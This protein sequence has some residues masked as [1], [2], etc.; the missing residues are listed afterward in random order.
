VTADAARRER[1]ERALWPAE[2]ASGSVWAVL[3]GARDPRIRRVLIESGLDFRS[4]YEGR[5]P[6]A[7]DR[8]APQLVELIPGQRLLAALFGDG[9][10]QAWGCFCRT[11]D[12]TR[13]RHHLRKLLKVRDERGRTLLFRFYDPR[14]LRVYLPTCRSDELQQVFGPIDAWFAESAQGAGLIEFRLGGDELVRRETLLEAA[15]C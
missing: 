6:A 9:W 5:V 3:D 13:L 12:P 8:V 10:G 4:L 2:G 11:D 14:V 1:I 7:I 15:A